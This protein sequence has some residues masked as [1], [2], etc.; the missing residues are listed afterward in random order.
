MVNCVGGNGN[1]GTLRKVVV[2]EGDARAR[3]D[4]AGET[5]GGGGVYAQGFGYHVV[6]TTDETSAGG[7]VISTAGR[8]GV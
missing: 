1:D 8:A 3:R 6:E 2:T 7:R 5:K 4:D